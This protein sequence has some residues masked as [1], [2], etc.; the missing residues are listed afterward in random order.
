[1]LY[2]SSVFQAF[3]VAHML[4]AVQPL[5]TGINIAPDHIFRCS[6]CS[7]SRSLLFLAFFRPFSQCTLYLLFTPSTQTMYPLHVQRVQ[8]HSTK[9]ANESDFFRWRKEMCTF[10]MEHALAPHLGSS[11]WSR[12]QTM[13][14]IIIIIWR[15][16]YFFFPISLSRCT[17]IYLFNQS[18]DRLLSAANGFQFWNTERIRSVGSSRE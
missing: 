3:S 5:G 15:E 1:M 9:Y 11:I 14:Q 10:N 16:K 4:P 8:L 6:M 7:T 17:I 12:R 2:D 18:W 13:L